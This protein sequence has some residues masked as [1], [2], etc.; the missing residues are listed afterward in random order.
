LSFFPLTSLLELIIDPA[1]STVFE[2]EKEDQNI[3][4]RPPRDLLQPMLNP[5]IITINLL[6]G[7]GVLLSTFALYFFVIKSGGGE[8]E[9]RSFAFTSLVLANI[10]LIVVNLSW[11]KN[12]F[13]I[14]LFANKTLLVAFGGALLCLIAVLYIPFFSGL[15]HLVPLHFNDFLLIILVVSTSLVWFEIGKLFNQKAILLE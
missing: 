11:S 12:I 1:C 7:F 8:L 13:Q 4:K 6:Q 9:A 3:M 2:S 15:F 10:L 5:K 14:L